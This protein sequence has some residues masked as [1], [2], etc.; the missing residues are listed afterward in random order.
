MNNRAKNVGDGAQQE[1]WCS[2]GDVPVGG[3]PSV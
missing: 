2:V 1:I 3:M